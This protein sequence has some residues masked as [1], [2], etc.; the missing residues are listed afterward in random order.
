MTFEEWKKI[1]SIRGTDNQKI[2]WDFERNNPGLAAL[3]AQKEQEEQEQMRNIMKEPD[4]MA[5][6]RQIAKATHDPEFAI[7]RAKEVM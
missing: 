6:W 4:R 1:K 2:I 3:F 7:R 5:R